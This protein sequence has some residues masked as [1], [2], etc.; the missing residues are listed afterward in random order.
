M[1]LYEGGPAPGWMIEKNSASDAAIDVVGT[2]HGTELLLRYAIGGTPA[3]SPYAA[4]VMPA[5]PAIAGHGRLVFNGRALHPM[6]I[7]VQLRAPGGGAG[8]AAGEGERWQRSV[9]LDET[10]RTIQLPFDDFR[11]FGSV[12]P[13]PPTPSNI[14]SVESVLFVVDTVNTKLGSSGQI[15]LDDIKYAK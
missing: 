3:D 2:L 1:L 9:Y 12:A 10:S 8:G 7:R 15:W 13:A 4:F 6:R 11:P 5:T 14:E